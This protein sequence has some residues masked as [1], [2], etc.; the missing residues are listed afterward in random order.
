VR[1]GTI[2]TNIT[3]SLIPLMNDVYLDRDSMTICVDMVY[4]YLLSTTFHG[5]MKTEIYVFLRG[6]T[7]FV[8]LIVIWFN[9]NLRHKMI[10]ST[11]HVYNLMIKSSTCTKVMYISIRDFVYDYM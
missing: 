5:Y 10:V 9:P 4:P 6:Y 3:S 2:G 7:Q 11:F 1:Y 8:N